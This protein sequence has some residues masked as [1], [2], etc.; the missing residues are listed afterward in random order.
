MNK[1]EIATRSQRDIILCKLARLGLVDANNN[2]GNV[3][4]K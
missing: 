4:D 3:Y 1:T 2:K